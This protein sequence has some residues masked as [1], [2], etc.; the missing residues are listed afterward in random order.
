M[1]NPNL[2]TD[3]TN[4]SSGRA[5]ASIVERTVQVDWMDKIIYH[6]IGKSYLYP[7]G[8]P[9]HYSS[10]LLPSAALITHIIIYSERFT[11]ARSNF[12]LR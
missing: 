3:T 11:L 9:L 5:S 6:I 4:I 12:V 10:P 2:K 1:I 7:P 8:L